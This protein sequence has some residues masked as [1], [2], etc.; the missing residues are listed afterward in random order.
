MM[1]INRFSIPALAVII[2]FCTAGCK[3]N[4]NT[5]SPSADNGGNTAKSDSILDASDIFSE[6]DLLNT[7][8]LS[9]STTL[10]LSD[11]ENITVTEEGVYVI[12][13]SAENKTITVDAPDTA[14]VQ[15]VLD[16]IT[17]TNESAPAIYVASA[18]KCFITLTDKD[19]SLTVSGTFTGDG[20]DGVI[21]SKDDL[22]LN[23][24]GA[25]YITAADGNGIVSNDDLR[26][27]GGTYNITASGHGLEANDRIAVNGGTFKI[28][29][30][31]DAI[32]CKNPD[33]EELGWVYIAGGTFDLTAASDGIDGSSVVEIDDGALSVSGREGIE[34]T[35]VQING[36]NI[37]VNASDDGINASG[38]SGAYA[39]VVEFNGGYTR[40]TVGRGDTDAVDSNGAVIIN[41]G[42]VDVTSAVSSFDYDTTAEYNGGTVII[43]GAE[44][45]ELPQ[46]MMGHGG[47][48]GGMRGEPPQG[49]AMPDERR[50]RDGM[51]GAPRKAPPEGG[52]KP[53]RGAP[54]RGEAPQNT[55][56]N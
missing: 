54:P 19:S 55:Q 1:K 39:T 23:G 6:R 38:R 22:T 33:D 29:S 11:G 16:G 52:A 24:T 45:S 32:H 47:G 36:G 26:I 49:G 44:V 10:S 42:T 41:G 4:G 2:C 7:A 18:D 48:R 20:A 8:D 31:K 51:G 46:P 12:C 56:T 9:D 17:V 50:P 21:F 43:N 5:A 3:G 25:L 34:A 27:T 13:G 37:T 28:S 14:K 40:I 35:Y 15:L 53:E 30:Q